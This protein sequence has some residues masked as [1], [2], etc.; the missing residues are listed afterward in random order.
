M[1]A[2]RIHGLKVWL[3]GVLVHQDYPIGV[4]DDDYTEFLPLSR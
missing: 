1:L 4:E 2:A 3:N